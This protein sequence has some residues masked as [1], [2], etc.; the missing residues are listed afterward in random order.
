LNIPIEVIVGPAGAV[1]VLLWV[2]KSL[3]D[4]HR[5]HDEEVRQE[6]ESWKALA[7][8]LFDLVPPAVRTTEAVANV[9]ERRQRGRD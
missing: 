9:A 1:A 8:Q 7:L 5:K 3:W 6:K 4:A 2:A